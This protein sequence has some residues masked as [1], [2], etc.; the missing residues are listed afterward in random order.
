MYTLRKA[1]LYPLQAGTV[2]LETAE[3]ENN[4]HFIKEEYINSQQGGLG[5]MF[6]DFAQT[7]I[8]VEALH[9]EK[10]TLQSKPALITV[11]ALPEKGKPPFFKGAVGNF[12]IEAALEKKQFYY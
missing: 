11:K 10:V 6:R 2:E 8:P 4:I 7:S 9:D 1:Q 5:N 12:A 3:V